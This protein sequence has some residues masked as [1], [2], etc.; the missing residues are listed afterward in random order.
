M[1]GITNSVNKVVI[2]DM[3]RAKSKNIDVAAEFGKSHRKNAAN[4]VVIG[5]SSP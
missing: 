2:E 5:M 1:N 4:F 3:L